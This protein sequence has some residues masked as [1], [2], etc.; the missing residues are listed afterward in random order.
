MKPIN[1]PVGDFVLGILLGTTIVSSIERGNTANYIFAGLLSAI[2]VAIVILELIATREEQKY[3][4][5]IR[6]QGKDA[7][8]ESLKLSKALNKA[9]LQMMQVPRMK[10]PASHVGLEFHTLT[11]KEATDDIKERGRKLF[12][13]EVGGG[14]HT[15]DNM[16]EPARESWYRYVEVEDKEKAEGDDEHR[17]ASSEGPVSSDG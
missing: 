8:A 1:R 7:E 2:V 9:M 10:T 13:E 17:E 6:K 11:G 15:W 16:G 5:E 14:D 3:K 12:D 4:A